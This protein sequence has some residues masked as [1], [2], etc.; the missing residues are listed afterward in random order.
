MELDLHYEDDIKTKITIISPVH[1]GTGETKL[2]FEY[3]KKNN[4]MYNYN[5][6]QLF[7][8]IPDKVLL[9]YRFLSS[10]YN[11]SNGSKRDELNKVLRNHIDY[12]KSTSQY[13]LRAD[14]EDDQIKNV[15][16]Q[17]KSL[18]KPYIPGSSL[19]GA[20][21]NAI[22]YDFI[23]NHFNSFC[24]YIK[25]E[26][27]KNNRLKGKCNID[28]FLLDYYQFECSRSDFVE[29]INLFASC[30]MFADVF[31]D[32]MVLVHAERNKVYIDK[33]SVNIPIFD[34][35]CIDANQEFTGNIIKIDSRKRNCLKEKYQNFKFY[36]DLIEYISINKIIKVCRNY[37]KEII[38]EEKEMEDVNNYYNMSCIKQMYEEVIPNSFYM[39]IGRNT[40][41]FFKTI[42]YLIKKN[43]YKLYEDYFYKVFSLKDKPKN[44][45]NSFY[46]KPDLM[47]ATRMFY[48]DDYYDYYPGVIKI[49][50]IK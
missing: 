49:E 39:R 31:F 34:F 8:C 40:N 47:P 48:T 23:R 9:D 36:D 45:K 11:S 6:Q 41:Y 32:N 24:K 43:N 44:N 25:N 14:F 21:M 5:L 46:P 1:I 17:V 29:F 12:T 13:Q 27:K 28:D 19:K 30:F 33:K 7:S 15:A 16:V 50:F 26:V 2:S 37:F 20:V 22:Y 18:N 38:G 35:E 4:V 3:I 42:S 10:L